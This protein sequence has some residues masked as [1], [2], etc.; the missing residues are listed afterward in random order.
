MV[1]RSIMPLQLQVNPVTSKYKFNMKTKQESRAWGALKVRFEDLVL[2]WEQVRSSS[3][4]VAEIMHA[5]L[6]HP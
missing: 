3:N 6:K 1:G 4:K 5:L 2:E